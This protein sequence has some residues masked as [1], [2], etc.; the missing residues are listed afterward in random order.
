LLTLD[1]L[2]RVAGVVPGLQ[3]AAATAALAQRMVA[4]GRAVWAG[5]G[6]ALGVKLAA[7][8]QRAVASP[9]VDS[10]TLQLRATKAALKE[11][12][13]R[14]DAEV[15]RAGQRARAAMA[16]QNK[17]AALLHL[18]RKRALEALALQRLGSLE[19]VREVLLR[20]D[21]ADTDAQLLRALQ[22]GRELLADKAVRAVRAASPLTLVHD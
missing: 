1:K 7:D 21:V 2:A 5:A 10:G 19:T 15:Q 12:R 13:L 20:L 17:P 4:T 3:A 16:A 14:L 22:A 9:A 18:K 6:P 8:G 11:Q